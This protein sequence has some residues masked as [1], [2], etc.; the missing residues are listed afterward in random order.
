MMRKDSKR[1]PGKN[2]MAFGGKP[3]YR[4]TVEVAARIGLVHVVYHNYMFGELQLPDDVHERIYTGDGLTHAEQCERMIKLDADIYVLLS[5]S[6]PFR[7]V[8]LYRKTIDDFCHDPLARVLV[9][10]TPCRPGRY[11][12]E[13][14]RR[15]NAARGQDGGTVYRDSGALFIFRRAQLSE[16]YF[17]DCDDEDRRYFIDPVGIDI[18]TREDLALAEVYARRWQA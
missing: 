6:S 4:W 5:P 9:S 14:R 1:L 15:V 18:D 3:L 8:E 10:L 12:D 13:N 11:H 7:D 2:T 17:L 16:P